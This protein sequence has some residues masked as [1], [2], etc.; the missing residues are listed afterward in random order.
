MV[1]ANIT[2]KITTKNI[3]QKCLEAFDLLKKNYKEN[4]VFNVDLLNNEIAVDVINSDFDR[5]EEIMRLDMVTYQHS[6]EVA[7]LAEK[8]ADVFGINKETV[9]VSALFHDLGKIFDERYSMEIN[10][11]NN[12]SLNNFKV[13]HVIINDIIC[14]LKKQIGKINGS[15]LEWHV[16]NVMTCHHDRKDDYKISGYPHKKFVLGPSAQ[17]IQIADTYDAMKR[18]GIYQ[19]HYSDGEIIDYLENSAERGIYNRYF[20][21]G[22]KKVLGYPVDLKL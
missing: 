2:T 6:K 11:V 20:V 13:E 18:R 3:K 4:Y 12:T 14:E 22:L 16:V 8:I 10:F 15:L 9:V 17:I 1:N 7:M 19:K 21:K 5:I